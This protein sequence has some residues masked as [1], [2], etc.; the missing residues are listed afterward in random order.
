MTLLP[1][2]YCLR[3][4]KETFFFFFFKNL[5]WVTFDFFLGSKPQYIRTSGTGDKA[6]LAD[7]GSLR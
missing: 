6:A 5:C 7:K 1:G 2:D 3:L 4:E